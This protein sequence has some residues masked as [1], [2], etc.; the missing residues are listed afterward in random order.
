MKNLLLASLAVI[1][2]LSSQPAH[3][4]VP[5]CP[6][7]ALPYAMGGSAVSGGPLFLPA[8]GLGIGASYLILSQN[9]KYDEPVWHRLA[10]ALFGDDGRV[11]DETDSACNHIE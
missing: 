6:T 4:V 9:D 1:A 10:C 5:P 11:G 8:V 2:L 7:C 3:A